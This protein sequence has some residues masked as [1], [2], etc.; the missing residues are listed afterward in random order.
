MKFFFVFLLFILMHSMIWVSSNWQ[1]VDGANKSL[2]LKLCIAL[3]IPI[4]LMAFYGTKYAYDIMESAWSVRLLAFSISYLT[5]PLLT[6]VFLN[7]SPFTTKT[8]ACIVLSFM[9]IGIQVL[10]RNS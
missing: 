6:W 2:A 8:L 3:A 9:I 10:L 7:E 5:F 4:S 1:L